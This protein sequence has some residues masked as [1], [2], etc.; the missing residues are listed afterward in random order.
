LLTEERL[1]AKLHMG[2]SSTDK[3]EYLLKGEKKGEGVK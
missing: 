1:S 3:D 2:S